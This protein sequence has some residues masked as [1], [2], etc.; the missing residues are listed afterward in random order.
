MGLKY[1]SSGSFV[2]EYLLV[3]I[4]LLGDVTVK[5]VVEQLRT[6]KGSYPSGDQTIK[7]A[8]LE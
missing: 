7:R 2:L 6:A 3:D 8:T 5:T 4:A 1:V